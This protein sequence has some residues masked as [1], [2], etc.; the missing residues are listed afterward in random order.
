[1][2][3][4]LVLPAIFG[5]L[6]SRG[7]YL[8]SL[9]DWHAQILLLLV[10][11]VTCGFY[12]WQPSAITRVYELILSGNPSHDVGRLYHK[13]IWRYLSLVCGLA[14]VLFD[15]PKRIADY[16]S[17]WMTQNWLTI[18]GREASLAL[19]FYIL[20][21]IA[22]RQ[23]IATVEWNRLLAK[24]TTATVLKAVTN[25]GLGSVF[26]LA[27]LGVRVGVEGIELPQ[28]P[29]TG[30]PDYYIYCAKIAVYIIAGLMLFFV[31]IA[32]VRRERLG[33]SLARVITLL[34]L[35]GIMALPLLAYIMLKLVL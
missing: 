34:K 3:Y 20:S 7:Q 25:Y 26:L 35:A 1:L 24:P 15:G 4:L 9:D 23:L 12:L 8:G 30:A 22:W 33:I 19:A 16:G 2:I 17:W 11:P 13:G 14:V 29:G 6:W 31:P 28:R 5:G 21:M 18:A 32:R 10:F 27:L